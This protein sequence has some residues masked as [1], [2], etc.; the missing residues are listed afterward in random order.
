M[1]TRLYSFR[2][3]WWQ[4]DHY[5]RHG[6]TYNCGSLYDR[7]RPRMVGAYETSEYTTYKFEL[8]GSFVYYAGYSLG[9]AIQEFIAHRLD[10]VKDITSIT[11]V[12]HR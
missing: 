6:L 7:I 8:G 2:V 9:M 10:Q 12:P 1:T 5:M 11:E 3:W 4:A